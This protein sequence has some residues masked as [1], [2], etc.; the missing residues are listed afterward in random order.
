MKSFDD[1]FKSRIDIIM[2]KVEEHPPSEDKGCRY[3]FNKSHSWTIRCPEYKIKV[4][5]GTSRYS[6]IEISKGILFSFT[7][8][9]SDLR[10]EHHKIIEKFYDDLMR[11]N[12]EKEENNRKAGLLELIG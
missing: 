3:E 2:K 10:S 11:S 8:E 4:L 9:S 6:K 7:I 5:P 1:K 12:R